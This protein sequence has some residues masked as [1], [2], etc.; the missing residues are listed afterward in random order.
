MIN[1]TKLWVDILEDGEALKIPIYKVKE[2]MQKFPPFERLIY[3]YIASQIRSVENLAI[4]LSL[5]DT[6]ERLLK[7]LLK[8]IDTIDKKGV[9]LLEKLSHSEIANLIGTVRHIIDR[10]LKELKKENIIDKE[11][12][13]IILKDAKK[14]LEM[15]KSY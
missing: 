11:K 5:Y 13:R 4:D 10:H 12:R 8:N 14:L 6:K 1:L 9:N 7:L 2:W 15:L 3:K